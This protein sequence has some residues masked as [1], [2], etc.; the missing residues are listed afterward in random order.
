MI[1]AAI[2]AE[3]NPFHNGHKYLIS[4]ARETG[5]ERVV[6]V[7]SG[8][9][10]QRGGCAVFDKFFR[11]KTAIENGVDLVLELPCPFSCS[12]GEIFASAAVEIAAALGEN[13]V[14][15]LYF[16]CESGDAGLIKKA[17]EASKQL[18]NSDMVKKLLSEGKSYPLAVYEAACSEYGEDIGGLLKNPNSILAVEYA[19]AVSEKAPW[20]E[21]APVMR[22]AVGHHDSEV[23]GEYASATRLREMLLN[24]E[25]ISRFVPH[26]AMGQECFFTERMEKEILFRLSCADKQEL[27]RLPD[28]SGELA[29]RIILTARTMPKT[30]DDF[31]Q[32]CKSKNI[33]MARLRRV[34]TYLM[35]GVRKDDLGAVP[36][37]RVLA[38][39]QRGREILG[40][41]KNAALPVGV[42]LKRLEQMSLYAKRVS[43]L[44]QNA[45]RFQYF[46]GERKEPFISDYVRKISIYRGE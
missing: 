46:C 19:K 12:S 45:V 2:V 1:T 37:A 36:Y 7:M 42:S 11:A 22:K 6:A 35:L 21:L 43:A 31:L 38:F 17:A 20:I 25:D 27:M 26:G 15:R 32:G 18:K 9:A 28:V 23:S 13:I 40:E 3:Y 16:G 39:D 4:K 30:L 5:A 41:C 44:E 33:T 10:V 24:G 14:N 8:A 29:D 34:V